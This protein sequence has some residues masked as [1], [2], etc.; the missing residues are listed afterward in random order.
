ML[1]MATRLAGITSVLASISVTSA[2]S[3]FTEGV[4]LFFSLPNLSG[5]MSIL[6]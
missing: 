5:S 1:E 6:T 4:N 2:S 3:T